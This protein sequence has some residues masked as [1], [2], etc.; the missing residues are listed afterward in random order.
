MNDVGV[1]GVIMFKNLKISTKLSLM[2]APVI[3]AMV[4]LIIA[5]YNTA[6]MT[7]DAAKKI[8]YKQLYT[9]E[10]YMLNA[11]RDFYQ[12]ELAQ[13]KI[14]DNRNTVT[15]E[16]LEKLILD[17][18][19]NT[20]EVEMHIASSEEAIKQ[21]PDLYDYYNC[22]N[23]G[24]ALDKNNIKLDEKLDRT[25]TDSDLTMQQL[26]ESF[27]TNIDSW[28]NSYNV[29]TGDGDYALATESFGKAR[30]DLKSMQDILI[31]YSA[32]HTD[33]LEDS[34]Q[35]KVLGVVVIVVAI[36]V[37]VSLIAFYIM[38]YI[39]KGVKCIT[40]NMD[41]LANKDLNT[42]VPTINSSDEFGNL[43]SSVNKV[44][45]T[46]R[47]IVLK[48]KLTSEELANSSDAMS[49][50]TIQATDSLNNISHSID[51]ISAT[52][53][54]QAND[55]EQAA[56]E[57]ASLERIAVQSADTSKNLASASR[58]VQAASHEGMDSVNELYTITQQNQAAFD[59]I[60]EIINKITKSAEKIGEASGLIAGIATQTNLLSLNAS[61]EAAR[62]GEAGK[63]FAVVAEEIRH[64]AEQSGG[65]VKVIDEMLK[66]LQFNV[67]HADEQ[68]KLVREA[69]T[70]QTSSVIETKEKYTTIVSTMDTINN[71]ITNLDSI[72]QKMEQSCSQVVGIISNLSA[73]AEENA[74][75][76]EQT[77]G[78]SQII[79]DKMNSIEDA[80]GMVNQFASELN[81]I[82]SEFHLD[83]K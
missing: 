23:L 4:G 56:A 80:N 69:V 61:I 72:N 5:Y 7:Y 24:A 34:I 9:I 25:L 57:I 65:S 76:A 68:S 64:L 44:L 79:L 37:F 22:N 53:S 29:Q 78:A 21:I 82:I 10:Y 62:A 1:K 49:N 12:A 71:E 11:D 28:K 59:V 60:F 75:I 55:T 81:E 77:A 8:Y 42:Q 48:L 52:V 43:S 33:E 20:G 14:N 19:S 63:G 3:L 31:A 30:A 40:T 15:T 6:F 73:S 47:D 38:N 35:S 83:E 74:A 26:F 54:T 66:E 2:I 46:L 13:T 39:R 58:S 41:S 36:V 50:N 67:T 16:E 27:K 70:K 32:L 51:E 17:H 18:E 45:V